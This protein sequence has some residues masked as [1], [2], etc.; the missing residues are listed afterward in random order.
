MHKQ[1]QQLRIGLFRFPFEARLVVV[2]VAYLQRRAT[3]QTEPRHVILISTL[4]RQTY[5]LGMDFVIS[6]CKYSSC[7]FALCET[8]GNVT[9][10]N[11]VYSLKGITCLHMRRA[12][13][14]SVFRNAKKCYGEN[15]LKIKERRRLVEV[16][17]KSWPS[18]EIAL[19]FIS[20]FYGNCSAFN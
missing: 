13:R 10:L 15:V 1:L 16:S 5:E 6:I 18:H 9:E 4:D 3:L 12:I 19:A 20:H 8:Y 11:R 7:L 2:V 14:F 17:A